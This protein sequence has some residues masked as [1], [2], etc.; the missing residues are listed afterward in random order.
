MAE[1]RD[2]VQC[3]AAVEPQREH[4]RFCSAGC[5]VAWNRCNTRGNLTSD[6]ALSWSLS[7]LND[8]TQRLRKATGMDL[9]DALAIVSESVWWVTLVDATMFRYHQGAYEHAFGRLS[10]AGRHATEGTFAGLRF[11]RNWMG[12]RADPADFI[13]PGKM[14]MDT[15]P[16][17][18]PGRG[19]RC[20]PW[21]WAPFHRKGAPG[22]PPA[23]GTI[24]LSWPAGRSV[25]PSP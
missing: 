7:A 21:S 11:V 20:P 4:A 14:P 1:L 9:P 12:Y 22:K 5:R 24:A 18:P 10:P 8:T 3:G 16:Q 17:W 15:K 19:T 2:C 25:R 13:Q 6:T 23:T